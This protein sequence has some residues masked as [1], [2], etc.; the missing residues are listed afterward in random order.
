MWRF[1]RT[2]SWVLK[3]KSS[4][5]TQIYV[6]VEFERRFCRVNTYSGTIGLLEKSILLDN[7]RLNRVFP[8]FLSHFVGKF[9]WGETSLESRKMHPKAWFRRV[10]STKNDKKNEKIK[11]GQNVTQNGAKCM[12]FYVQNDSQAESRRIFIRKKSMSSVAGL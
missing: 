7:L 6:E 8:F 4:L 11:N 1:V 10:F 2:L 3:C 9:S 5:D 12:Y